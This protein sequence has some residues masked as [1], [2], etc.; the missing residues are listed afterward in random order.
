MAENYHITVPKQMPNNE[1]VAAA[2]G[3]SACNVNLLFR[4]S[5]RIAPAENPLKC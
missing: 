4:T 5:P 2:N 1:K 3:T